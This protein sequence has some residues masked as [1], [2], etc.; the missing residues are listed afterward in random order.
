MTNRFEW[1]LRGEARG[2]NDLCDAALLSTPAGVVIPSVGALVPG[3]LLIVPRARVLSYA[4]LS[5]SIRNELFGLSHNLAERVSALGTPMIL[6]HGAGRP[7]SAVGC[8]IDQAHLHVVPVNFDL[9]EQVLKDDRVAWSSVPHSDPWASLDAGDEYYLIATRDVAFVG[10][11]QACESQYF[12]RH[13]ARGVG[14]GDRWDYKGW[15]NYGNVART[16]RE[17]ER[18][19]SA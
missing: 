15:P 6:E 11:P 3:W 18:P 19:A 14:L 12:R 5:Q 1:I 8:G 17:F 7:E 16:I 13:I 2:P 9:L 4:A 10:I